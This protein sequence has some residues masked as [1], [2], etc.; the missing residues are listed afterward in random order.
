MYIDHCSANLWVPQQIYKKDAQ[1]KAYI[2][3]STTL[4]TICTINININK[5]HLLPMQCICFYGSQNK[6]QLFPY[7]VLADYVV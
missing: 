6:Q 4:V 5:F 1:K 2:N 7:A 3:L